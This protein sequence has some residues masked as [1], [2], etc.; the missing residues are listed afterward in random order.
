MGMEETM[1]NAEGLYVVTR[2]LTLFHA[3]D[4]DTGTFAC[5]A[6]ASISGFGDGL[7]R[8]NFDLT[9]LSMC[10]CTGM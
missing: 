5:T 4:G 7:D 2:D 9:V 10:R 6:S 8:V 1:L 3:E